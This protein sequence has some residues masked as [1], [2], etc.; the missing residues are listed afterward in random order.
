LISA[1]EVDTRDVRAR[2]RPVLPVGIGWTF[3]T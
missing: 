1:S 3:G 2:L